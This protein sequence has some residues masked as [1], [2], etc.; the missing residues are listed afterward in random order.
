[1]TLRSGPASSTSPRGRRCQ[2]GARRRRRGGREGIRSPRVGRGPGAVGPGVAS[3]RPGGARFKLKRPRRRRTPGARPRPSGAA[4]A[5]ARMDTASELPVAPAGPALHS[6]RG[7]RPALHPPGRG[8]VQG[9]RAGGPSRVPGP[10]LV[11]SRVRGVTEGGARRP[12]PARPRAP[13]RASAG[14]PGGR[15]HGAPAST[16]VAIG[17]PPLRRTRCAPR[18]GA[19]PGERSWTRGEKAAPGLP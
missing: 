15:W 14:S 17:G 19:P 12:I 13:P 5:L 3:H 1:M 18:G 9:W 11:R 8:R 4:L 2:G 7:R 10:A 16:R 6:R